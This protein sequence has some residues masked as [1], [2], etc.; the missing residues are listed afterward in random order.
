[1]GIEKRLATLERTAK[2]NNGGYI[3]RGVVTPEEWDALD[4]K[5]REALGGV[6]VL[7]GVVTPEEWEKWPL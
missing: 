6:F 4:D 1:M 2:E 3:C 5:Q 7:P